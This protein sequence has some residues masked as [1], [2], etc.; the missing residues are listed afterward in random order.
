M[1]ILERIVCSL[2]YYSLIDSSYVN[3]N[4]LNLINHWLL[5]FFIAKTILSNKQIK[6]DHHRCFMWLDLSY[7]EMKSG[8]WIRKSASRIA[9]ISPDD[10]LAFKKT[11]ELLRDMILSFHL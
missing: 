3:D 10:S 1:L 6:M 8:A 7:L 5:I 2:M 4:Y 11:R 9:I